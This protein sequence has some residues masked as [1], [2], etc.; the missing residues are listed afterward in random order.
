VTI[1]NTDRDLVTDP[2]GMRHEDKTGRGKPSLIPTAAL[3]RDAVHYEVGGQIHGDRNWEK[4]RN[5]SYHTDAIARHLWDYIDR[6]CDRE[7]HLAA[8]RWHAAAL[9]FYEARGRDHLNDLPWGTPVTGSPAGCDGGADLSEGSIPFPSAE[10]AE[11][12]DRVQALSDVEYI[13]QLA[14][15][16]FRPGGLV[17]ERAGR[18]ARKDRRGYRVLAYVA[19]PFSADTAARKAINIRD[20]KSYAE[21]LWTRGIAVICPHANTEFLDGHASLTWGDFLAGDLL[22]V[23]RCDVLVLLPG[24]EESKGACREKEEAEKWGIPVV[25]GIDCPTFDD[26]A[27]E[28]YFR[29]AGP[30]MRRS[31]L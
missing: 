30:V 23:Q 21:A 9:M 6:G 25:I 22:M 29:A 13:R 27:K 24:W 16:M 12:S 15:I 20:A 26:L 18:A 7:D 5:F 1:A 8:I 3:R 4:G 2:N 28:V 17:P 10:D 19:G 11:D 14:D 31:G